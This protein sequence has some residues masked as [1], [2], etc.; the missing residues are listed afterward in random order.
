MYPVSARFLSAVQ[1]SH[2]MKTRVDI[3]DVGNNE[4]IA[5]PQVIG[6]DVTIDNRRMVRR[7][8]TIDL[9]D[10]DGTWVPRNSRSSTLLV[11]NREARIYR[12]VVFADGTEELVPLGVFSLTDVDIT[13]TAEGVKIT[14]TGSDRSLRVAE[15]KFTDHSFYIPDATAKETAIFNIIQS[16]YSAV[17]AQLPATGQVTKL[18]YPT[19]DQSSDPWKEATAIASSA[20]MDLYFDEVGTLRMRPIPGG[21]MV[22]GMWIPSAYSGKPVATYTADS[23]LVITQ[24]QR[25]L[26]RTESYNGVIYT[27]EGTNLTLGVIGTAWDDDPSSPTYR[28]TYGEVPKFMSSP[29]ILTVSEATV[30]ARAE[31]AKVIGA[32]ESLDWNQIVNPALDVYDVLEITRA[33][34]G[35]ALPFSIDAITIPLTPEGTMALVGKSRRFL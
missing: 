14:V 31:L 22:D 7:Q 10:N 6:G 29:T 18:L 1:K 8:C 16:R 9:V 28:K 35:V 30:A 21:S 26:S 33:K 15:A 20:G 5:S 12:G 32:T 3:Y 23:N 24:L 27:G 34:S 4:I 11:F 2:V 25:K 13:D 17:I 19:L